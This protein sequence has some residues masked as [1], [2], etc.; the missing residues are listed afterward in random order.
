MLVFVPEW[1]LSEV[2]AAQAEVEFYDSESLS[3]SDQYHKISWA[4]DRWFWQDVSRKV[5][6][7]LGAINWKNS[8]YTKG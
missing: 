3:P 2:G 1:S 5:S 8:S 4:E 7:D 6:E